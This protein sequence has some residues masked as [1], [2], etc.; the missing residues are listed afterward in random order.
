MDVHRA[1]DLGP[2][3]DEGVA[4]RDPLDADEAPAAERRER[5]CV[6]GLASLYTQFRIWGEKTLLFLG[7]MSQNFERSILLR[8]MKA[9]KGK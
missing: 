2:L 4:H 9:A 7:R 3:D 6:D 8:D 5:R 1:H